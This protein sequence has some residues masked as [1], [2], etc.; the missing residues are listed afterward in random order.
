MNFEKDIPDYAMMPAKEKDTISIVPITK[1]AIYSSVDTTSITEG[2]GLTLSIEEDILVPDIKPD[3]KEI[4]IMEGSCALSTRE[5]TSSKQ[6]EYINLSGHLKL[7]TLYI[8]EK[9]NKLCPIISMETTIPFKEQLKATPSSSA[10]FHCKVDKIEYSIVNERKYK[11]RATIII[12]SKEFTQQTVNLFEGISNDKLEVLK[13]KMEFSH[14][15]Q[16]KKDVLSIK[17]NI[18]SFADWQPGDIMLSS[19]N[20]VENYKQ[21]SQDKVIVNGFVC[22]NALC[23]DKSPIDNVPLSSNFKQIQEKVEFTQFIPISCGNSNTEAFTSFDCSHLSLKLVKHED[24]Q[25]ILCL[26]GELATYIELYKKIEKEVLVD[27]YH[28]EKKFLC[29]YAQIN[30]TVAT[31]NIFSESSIREIFV[32]K[33]LSCDIE[34]IIFT[35]GKIKSIDSSFEQG[36]AICSGVIS[37]IMICT[38]ADETNS[39]FSLTEEIPFRLATTI[40]D[41]DKRSKISFDVNLKD[42][43]SEKINGKQLEFN[44]TIVIKYDAI[45]ETSFKLMSSPSFAPMA[46]FAHHSPMVIYCCKENE[47]LWQIAKKFRTST[48]NIISINHLESDILPLGKKLLIIK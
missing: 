24:G 10:F 13:E 20:I 37:A 22:V 3:L 33:N 46:A 9:P 17:E 34:D 45:K 11:V 15:V 18:S 48:D 6:D 14:L 23:Y 32:P 41:T 39:V 21:V 19:I 7:Q 12:S 40:D 25:N 36:K 38:L 31:G 26:E 43:W 8:P 42:L 29:E 35:S 4:L 5:F 2:P 1:D 44:G 27:A 28:R 16:R 47:S 30:N